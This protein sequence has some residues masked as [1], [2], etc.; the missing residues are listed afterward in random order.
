MCFAINLKEISEWIVD[1]KSQEDL[2]LAKAS[3]LCALETKFYYALEG[4]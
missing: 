2:Q 3:K 4:E 1:L